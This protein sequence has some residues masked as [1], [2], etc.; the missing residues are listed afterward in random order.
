MLLRVG[1]PS[2]VFLL[3]TLPLAA[4]G[5]GFGAERR[6]R[7]REGINLHFSKLC[8]FELEAGAAKGAHPDRNKLTSGSLCP[9][10][11][12]SL[13]YLLFLQQE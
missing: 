10:N 8:R 1:K 7:D 12:L 13:Q 4:G 9:L 6:R 3:R 11:S 5:T 2:S